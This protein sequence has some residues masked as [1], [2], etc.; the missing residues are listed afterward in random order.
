[1]ARGE[2]NEIIKAMGELQINGG[3]LQPGGEYSI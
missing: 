1:M 3:K 2:L